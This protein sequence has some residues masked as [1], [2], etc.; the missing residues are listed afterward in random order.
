M[1]AGVLNRS[2]RPF[3]VWGH[4][5]LTSLD[6]DLRLKHIATKELAD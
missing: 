5:A 1:I 4:L 6:G 3:H 2:G